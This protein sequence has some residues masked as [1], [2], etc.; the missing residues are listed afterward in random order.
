MTQALHKLRYKRGCPDETTYPLKR[1]PAVL[2]P[3]HSPMPG[4]QHDVPAFDTTKYEEFLREVISV[5]AQVSR[6]VYPYDFLHQHWP[7]KWGTMES[8]IPEILKLG[9]ADASDPKSCANLVRMDKPNDLAGFILEWLLSQKVK[10]KDN[11]DPN[12]PFLKLLPKVE[13]DCAKAVYDALYKGFQV[14]WHYG[15]ARPSEVWEATT[16]LPADRLELY[17]HPLHP[18]Y[19]AGHSVA[20]AATAKFFLDTFVLSSTQIRQIRLSAYL[21]GQYRT[22]AGVHY[23]VDNIEGLKLGGLE[24]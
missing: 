2:D 24:F 4:V 10:L 20:S 16:G 19:I 23:A 15:I 12:F 13:S 18:S 9:G 11:V 8:D 7:A 22:F 14:K 1:I 17:P 5:T 21:F 3:L 6:D